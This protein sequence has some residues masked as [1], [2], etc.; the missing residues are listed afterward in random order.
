L[1]ISNQNKGDIINNGRYKGL[2]SKQGT[3]T[4]SGN[5]DE[6][7]NFLI[8]KIQTKFSLKEIDINLCILVCYKGECNFELTQKQ[9]NTIIKLD[10]PLGITCY[11]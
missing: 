1:V 3:L 10:I 8:S 4:I 2:I 5:I 11:E 7:L 9:L 6:V